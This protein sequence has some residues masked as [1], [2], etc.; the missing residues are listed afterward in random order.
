MVHKISHRSISAVVLVHGPSFHSL[1]LALYC[2]TT[3]Y[4][5]VCKDVKSRF[6][7]AFPSHINSNKYCVV[8]SPRATNPWTRPRKT[9]PEEA[10]E[11]FTPLPHLKY[12][13]PPFS[14]SWSFVI[15]CNKHFMNVSVLYIEDYNKMIAHI[16]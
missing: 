11:R 2:I 15:F 1:S 6:V 10:H 4:D 3:Y 14:V 7:R 9:S 13:L 16:R 12:R 5:I 8:H